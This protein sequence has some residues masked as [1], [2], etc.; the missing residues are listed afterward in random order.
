M[1]LMSMLSS[2]TKRHIA[3]NKIG[4]ELVHSIKYS[5]F[6]ICFTIRKLYN[7]YYIEKMTQLFEI[8]VKLSDNQKKNISDAYR[9]RETIVIRLTNDSLSGGNDTLYVPATTKEEIEEESKRE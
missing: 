1:L 2:Y 5:S 3:I 9:K 8:K 4:N 6:R 7:I